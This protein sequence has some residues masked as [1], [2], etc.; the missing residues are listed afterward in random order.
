[1]DPLTAFGLATNILTFVEFSGK[2]LAD[3]RAVY[4]S[5][6]GA[7]ARSLDLEFIATQIKKRRSQIP[8]GLS[9]EAELHDLCERCNIV[10]GNLLDAIKKLKIKGKHRKWESFKV[11]L[12]ETLSEGEMF[13]LQTNMQLL[14]SEWIAQMLALMANEQNSVR[15]V[16]EKLA[17]ENNRR[18]EGLDWNVR[19]VLKAIEKRPGP[20]VLHEQ[21]E[22]VAT[23]VSAYREEARVTAWNQRLIESLYYPRFQSRHDAISE[24]HARTFEWVLSDT[25][26]DDEEPRRLVEWLR[27]RNGTYFVQG[28]AGSGKSTLMKFLWHHQSTREHLKAWG[29]GSK[30][31][32]A[33]YFFWAAGDELQ[34]SEEGLMRALLFEILRACPQLIEGIRNNPKDSITLAE[35]SR[36]QTWTITTLWR[37]FEVLM[38]QEFEA[39]FCFFIDGL[40]EYKGNTEELIKLVQ[41]LISYP[42][43]KICV[44]SRPWAEFRQAFGEGANEEWR[45]KLEDL[46]KVDIHQYV[47]DKLNQDAQYSRLQHSDAGYYDIAEQVTLRAQGVFLWV[48]LVVRSLLDG[49]RYDDTIADMRRRLD[50]LPNGLDDFFKLMLKGVDQFYRAKSA[51]SIKIAVAAAA[52]LPLVI[53]V[54]A[55]DIHEDP[56]HALKASVAE[57]KYP[58]MRDMINQMPNRI[59]A[60][61]KGLL[62]VVKRDDAP[63]PYHEWEVAFLHRTVRDFFDSSQEITK[64]FDEDLEDD[65]NEHALLCHAYL[66]NLKRTW[67]TWHQRSD[68]SLIEDIMYHAKQL[69]ASH[70]S[71]RRLEN[72][73]QEAKRVFYATGNCAN[74]MLFDGTAIRYGLESYATEHLF[75]SEQADQDMSARATDLLGYALFDMRL[76]IFFNGE[77]YGD[78]SI[79]PAIVNCLLEHGA[80][81]N[82][83]PSGVPD[84]VPLEVRGHTCWGEF[85]LGC[86]ERTPSEEEFAVIHDLI[87]HGADLGYQIRKGMSA[88]KL[89]QTCFPKEYESW[90]IKA[91]S[92]MKTLRN[93]F[94]GLVHRSS[95][96]AKQRLRQ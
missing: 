70:G 48:R 29:G 46:T 95:R 38:N 18:L 25:S 62:E 17:M 16:N 52:S 2:L 7:S 68:V 73:F 6:A 26:A 27:T 50:A 55:D 33:S 42:G 78:H 96:R 12:T 66:E 20:G 28:K 60:R 58:D 51:M 76:E 11:A 21:S 37:M 54:Y 89:L 64:S 36:A 94:Q 19:Q 39:K 47:D 5:G 74:D 22:M 93:S 80:N 71:T 92:P 81:P 84:E 56:E 90:A 75:G 49:A 88:G 23:K 15:L 41:K 65:F 34:K 1:M 72:V 67:P 86:A 69:Q 9:E 30:L 31:F 82:G 45:I 57:L 24:A 13:N 3:S 35:Q 10:G 77:K 44:S 79:N 8:S 4:K 91:P 83:V 85:V 53:H 61:S 63:N 14:Q 32:T 87:E 43:I 59:D 40:D